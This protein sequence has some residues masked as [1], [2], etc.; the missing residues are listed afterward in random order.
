MTRFRGWSW[1]AALAGATGVTAALAASGA[2]AHHSF[3]MFDKEHP[4]QLQGTVKTWEFTNPHS[5]LVMM[6][7]KDGR[8]TQVMVEGASVD[9]LIRQGFG[10]NTFAPGEKINL[11]ISPL[12]N[13]GLG[14]AF[15]KAIKAD[16]T[17]LTESPTPN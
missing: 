15:V 9:T 7:M 6:V 4:V 17:V 8:P 3:A 1:R 13:G 14:G 5:W 10:P 16:G 11:V 12:K 2:L